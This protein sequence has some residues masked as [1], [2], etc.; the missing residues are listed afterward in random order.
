[1]AAASVISA[2]SSV[3]SVYGAIKGA[4]SPK[5]QAPK[6]QADPNSLLAKRKKERS[7]SMRYGQGSEANDLSSNNTLG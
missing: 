3:A 7:L 6:E 4:E 1:M 2:L 5:I